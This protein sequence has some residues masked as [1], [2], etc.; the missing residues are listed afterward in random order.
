MY[1]H[2][3]Q[4]AK[5]TL[6]I[7]GNEREYEDYLAK[8]NLTRAN[9]VCIMNY[10]Q[11]DSSLYP[12]DCPIVVTGNYLSNTAYESRMY[13]ERQQFLQQYTNQTPS[14]EMRFGGSQQPSREEEYRMAL[15]EISVSQTTRTE[16]LKAI[17]DKALRG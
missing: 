7:A 12:M 16:D 13:R 10:R 8:H 11:L 9:A 15:Q 3:K 4:D 14:N 2:P 5:P 6:V 17:A 1:D